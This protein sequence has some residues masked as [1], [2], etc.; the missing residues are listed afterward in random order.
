MRRAPI[1]SAESAEKKGESRV[2]VR[3]SW[4][5]GEGGRLGIAGARTPLELLAF[6]YPGA[7]IQVFKEPFGTV[8][9]P[10]GNCL[11]PEE[12]GAEP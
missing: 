10:G 8:L 12:G 3:L 1:S 9:P 7:W 5:L 11:I 4:R 6:A 2:R